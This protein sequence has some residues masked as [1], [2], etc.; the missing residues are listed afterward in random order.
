MVSDIPAG[1]G[2]IEKLSLRCVRKSEK[3]IHVTYPY[4]RDT[5]PLQLILKVWWQRAP[6]ISFWSLYV[7]VDFT[8]S[9]QHEFVNNRLEDKIKY[10]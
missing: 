6:R 9:V 1:D 10:L 2:N 4:K 8:Y 5:N 3:H 7:A